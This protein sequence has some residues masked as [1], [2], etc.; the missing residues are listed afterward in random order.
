MKI[1]DEN[2]LKPLVTSRHLLTSH[3]KNSSKANE[4]LFTSGKF[5]DF[6]VIVNKSKIFKVHR[7]ILAAHSQGFA[8]MFDQDPDEVEMRIEDLSAEAV[9]IFLRFLYTGKLENFEAKSLEIFALATKLK[10]PDLK[11][12]MLKLVMT[13]LDESNAL[14]TLSFA[15]SIGSDELKGAAFEAIKKMFPYRKLP[16]SMIEI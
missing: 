4:A 1:I 13:R 15:H 12:S 10:V 8:E 7:N 9:E 11:E 6:S 2:C 14:K 5:S 3:L 16:K